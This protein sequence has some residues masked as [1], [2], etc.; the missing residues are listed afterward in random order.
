MRLFIAGKTQGV[1]VLLVV[2]CNTVVEVRLVT[3]HSA[4]LALKGF[5]SSTYFMLEPQRLD[6]IY[7][8]LAN[9]QN[10]AFPLPVLASSLP[11]PYAA[12][13]SKMTLYKVDAYSFGGAFCGIAPRILLNI[14]RR[15]MSFRAHSKFRLHQLANVNL[16]NCT[17]RLYQIHSTG[18]SRATCC[19]CSFVGRGDIPNEKMSFNHFPG[20]FEI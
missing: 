19:H 4:R 20:K 18:S 13:T 5:L 14:I 6:E 11:T 17:C 3:R 12:P 15:Q 2:F 10:S 8:R 7:I 1:Y 16:L 9:Q